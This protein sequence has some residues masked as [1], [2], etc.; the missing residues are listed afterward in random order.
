MAIQTVI[1]TP[2]KHLLD[3]PQASDVIVNDKDLQP[4]RELIGDRHLTGGDGRRAAEAS[5]ARGVAARGR[6]HARL[7]HSLQS[8]HGRE[9]SKNFFRV[10]QTKKSPNFLRRREN[11]KLSPF[12][13]GIEARSGNKT[14]AIRSERERDRERDESGG[15]S[16]S[17]QR[18]K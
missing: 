11:Q 12:Q 9:S 17:E 5:L 7:R 2:A 16:E 1:E 13:C 3:N 6:A 8:R 10:K 18:R 15:R 14:L 4:R